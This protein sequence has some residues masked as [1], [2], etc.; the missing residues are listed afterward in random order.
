MYT[1]LLTEEQR[2]YAYKLTKNQIGHRGDGSDGI[3][4]Q[5]YVGMVAEVAFADIMNKDRP[6]SNGFDDGI[7]FI[8]DG[9]KID[10]KAMGRKRH[11]KSNYT[12]NLMRSQV[13]G[14]GYKN[15]VYLFERG[16]NQKRKKARSFLCFWVFNSEK[17]FL[18]KR[19]R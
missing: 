18:F 16:K 2:V 14:E 19:S 9:V 7:D 3:K 8:I 5:P 13:E 11:Y 10:L 15:D 6:K 12:N 17:D 4:D 1:T